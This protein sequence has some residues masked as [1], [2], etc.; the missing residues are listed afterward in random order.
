MIAIDIPQRSLDWI[1][2]RLW[3]LT[4]SMMKG[5]ITSTGLLSKSQAALENVDKL[6]AGQD[7]ANAI[8]KNPKMFDDMDDWQIQQWI[9]NY[10]GNKFTGNLHTRR[11][12]DLE[13]DAL[14]A[15]QDRIGAQLRDVGLC[16]MGDKLNGVVSCSPDG[17]IY[18]GGKLTGGAETKAPTLATWYGYIAEGGLPDDYKL[19][20]HASMAICEVDEWHFG[21]YFA[22]KPLHYVRVT[23]DKFTDT[24]AASL[25]EFHGFYAERYHKVT[26]ALKSISRK[27]ELL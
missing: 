17:L 12:N 24:L 25:R 13:P 21:A 22:G 26:E 9:A 2:E 14:A 7:A 23:R 20:V 8:V 10:T 11:G 19:Q 18:S 5:N 6:I 16:I 27:E 3:R 1:T 4:A 15:V